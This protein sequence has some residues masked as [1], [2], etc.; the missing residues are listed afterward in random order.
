VVQEHWHDAGA[1]EQPVSK[2]VQLIDV[3]FGVPYTCGLILSA[4]H[5]LI[6]LLALAT[7]AFARAGCF[8]LLTR[9]GPGLGHEES[10]EK[11]EYCPTAGEFQRSD[12]VAPHRVCHDVR[13]V[14]GGFS[15][16]PDSQ[17]AEAQPT[18]S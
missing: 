6:W 8:L 9:D 12:L 7:P 3:A 5:K 4:D 10:P 14:T 2:M 16:D 18:D 13:L 1:A 11:Q 17:F 15:I